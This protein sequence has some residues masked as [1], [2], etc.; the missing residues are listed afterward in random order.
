[1][2]AFFKKYPSLKLTLKRVKY[3][4]FVLER[5]KFASI[6]VMNDSFKR[7]YIMSDVVTILLQ[8]L[9]DYAK[10]PWKFTVK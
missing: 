6:D 10:K 9:F 4:E 2:K 1:M 3:N 5:E 7:I 8:V